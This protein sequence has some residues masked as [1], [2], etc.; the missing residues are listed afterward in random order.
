MS[1]DIYRLNYYYGRPGGFAVK[2]GN[3]RTA[4]TEIRSSLREDCPFYNKDKLDVSKD[5][6]MGFRPVIADVLITSIQRKNQIKEAAKETSVPA[7]QS[8]RLSFEQAKKK[9]DQVYD[10]VTDASLKRE[11]SSIK[12]SYDDIAMQIREI[13][14]MDADSF[15][16]IGSHVAH[17]VRL[18]L[19]RKALLEDFLA[20]LKKEST[21]DKETVEKTKANV[22][23]IEKA[24]AEN[25]NSYG[26]AIENLNKKFTNA[27]DLVKNSYDR[28][29]EKLKLEGASDQTKT[30]ECVYAHVQKFLQRNAETWKADFVNLK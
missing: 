11:L 28:V 29:L 1:F 21:P 16:R 22:A 14:Q 23:Q 27:P 13:E 12:S 4:E 20:D 19:K 2:G 24:I 3:L 7:E 9:M 15:F 17:T 26:Y 30:T 6:N 25:L 10:Q 18:Q 5:P 8:M